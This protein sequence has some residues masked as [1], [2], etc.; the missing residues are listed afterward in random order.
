[1]K[2]LF[3]DLHR[4]WL[5]QP[6]AAPAPRHPSR[7]W[8]SKRCLVQEP[9]IGLASASIGLAKASLGLTSASIGPTNAWIGL[10]SPLQGTRKRGHARCPR[11]WLDD[12]VPRR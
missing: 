4:C 9:S 7:G 10:A 3:R 8:L 5:L 1:M 2:A 11:S 6:S 12:A